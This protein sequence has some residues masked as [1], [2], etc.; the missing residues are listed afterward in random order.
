V[1]C[2]RRPYVNTTRQLR[3][4]LRFLE[5]RDVQDLRAEVGRVGQ[6]KL[7]HEARLV[8]ALDESK[9]LNS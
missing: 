7:H 8:D 2:P 6:Q 1:A 5:L 4:W 9:W 3:S